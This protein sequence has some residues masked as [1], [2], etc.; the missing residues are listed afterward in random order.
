LWQ[1]QL[2]LLLELP[3]VRADIVSDV[4]ADAIT[5]RFANPTTDDTSEPCA[6][7][8]AVDCMWQQ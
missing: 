1:R 4:F 3:I 5:N 7:T 8:V 6:V 2:W